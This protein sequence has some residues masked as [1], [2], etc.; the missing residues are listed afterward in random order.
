MTST[1]KDVIRRASALIPEPGRSTLIGMFRPLGFIGDRVECP[2]CNGR[3]SR[4]MTHRGI[5][6]VRCPACN[7]MERHRLLWLYLQRETDLGSARRRVLH[8]APEYQLQR[9]LLALPRLE[10]LS[11]DRD[12]RLADIHCDLQDLPFAPRSFDVVIANHVLEH[13]ADDRKAIAEIARVLAD[14]GWAVLMC[15]IARGRDVTL[16]DATITTPDDR[17]RVYGQEDHVRLYG[18]DY[19]R[20]L[21]AGG[22]D[23]E[24]RRYLREL[25]PASVVRYGLRRQHDLF[26]E[27]DIFIARKPRRVAEGDVHRAG[28]DD[29]TE[30]HRER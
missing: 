30:I 13:V 19:R 12:S 6:N 18:A 2:C 14:G 3:F 24:T 8:V 16:E 26:D 29:S 23:V 5:P 22:F 21:A 28:D 10:Y 15:P 20:R 17:L 1:V 25:E 27:D 4:F 11:V 9:R 7:A